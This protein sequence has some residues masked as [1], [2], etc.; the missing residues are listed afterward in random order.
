MLRELRGLFEL[1]KIPWADKMRRF[2]KDIN[3]CKND[4]IANGEKSANAQTLSKID[5]D[6]DHL[7][8]QGRAALS[9]IKDNELGFDELRRMLN[10][11]T[12]YKDCYLLFIRNYTAPFTNNLAERDLRPWK[13]KQ[14]VSGCFRS[15]AGIQRSVR[16]RSFVSTAKKR[17]LS[18]LDSISRVSH[19]LPVLALGEE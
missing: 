2:I 17:K 6:Y 16:I 4:D 13:T 14:K 15:W 18:L 12:E 9:Q 10:R 7:I 3:D 11:L 1:Q 19:A 5:R 8:E